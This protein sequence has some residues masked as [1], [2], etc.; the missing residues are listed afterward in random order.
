MLLS[1]VQDIDGH[2]KKQRYYPMFVECTMTK[3]G[4]SKDQ[5]GSLPFPANEL[6]RKFPFTYN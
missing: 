5:E 3:E 6:Y 4:D 2:K 1:F